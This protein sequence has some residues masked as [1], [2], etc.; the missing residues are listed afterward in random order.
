MASAAS[1][2]SMASTT[3]KI[4]FHQKKIP[5]LNDYIPDST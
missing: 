5:D 1:E 2:T 3:L 4:I